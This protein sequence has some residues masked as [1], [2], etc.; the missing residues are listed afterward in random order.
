MRSKLKKLKCRSPRRAR[1]SCFSDEVRCL[2]TQVPEKETRVMCYVILGII[3]RPRLLRTPRYSPTPDGI[4]STCLLRNSGATGTA[5]RHHAIIWTISGAMT[6]S[7]DGHRSLMSLQVT[8][9]TRSTSGTVSLRSQAAVPSVFEPLFFGRAGSGL[10]E[11]RTRNCG[12]NEERTP[13][14]AVAFHLI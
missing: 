8:G 9:T 6:W 12:T 4:R 3:E 13:S 2:V 11:E 7:R 5:Q 1:N 14:S 10:D